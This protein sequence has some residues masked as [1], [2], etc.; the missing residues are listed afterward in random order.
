[1]KLQSP[2]PMMNV[3]GVK[4]SEVMSQKPEEIGSCFTPENSIFF[5]RAGGEYHIMAPG[6]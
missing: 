6:F 3:K 1:M 5:N 4:E 2:N